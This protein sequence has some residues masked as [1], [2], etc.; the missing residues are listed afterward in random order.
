MF[1]VVHP[2]TDIHAN[3]SFAPEAVIQQLISFLRKPY[4]LT[5]YQD[6]LLADVT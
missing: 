5:L 2:T 3:G 6:G 4:Q 1:S